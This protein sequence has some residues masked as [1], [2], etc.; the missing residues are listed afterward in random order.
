MPEK[1][2]RK[3]LTSFQM[4]ILGF[5]GV[6]LWDHSCLCYHLICGESCNAI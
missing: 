6:I 5:A 1:H 3:H 2:K 4:I